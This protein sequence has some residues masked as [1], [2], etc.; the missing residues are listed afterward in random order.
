MRPNRAVETDVP[1]AA[2]GSRRMFGSGSSQPSRRAC[3]GEGGGGSAARFDRKVERLAGLG[4]IDRDRR[5]V[6][7]EP[8]EVLEARAEGGA[9]RA[10]LEGAGEE[11]FP[12][13]ADDVA[14]LHVGEDV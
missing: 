7:G 11:V 5:H 1:Q 14:R 6:P 3:S 4:E 2:R 12:V 9:E 10:V 13:A 8:M